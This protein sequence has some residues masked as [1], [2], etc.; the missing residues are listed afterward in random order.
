[1]LGLVAL[2]FAVYAGGPLILEWIYPTSCSRPGS[3]PWRSASCTGT[4]GVGAAIGTFATLWVL[5]NLGI[6]GTMWIAARIA[7]VGVLVSYFTAPETRGRSLHEAV[8]L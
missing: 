2:A 1:L 7:G 4:S 3:E 8:W 5:S 6:S